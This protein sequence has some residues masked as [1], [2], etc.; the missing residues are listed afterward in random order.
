MDYGPMEKQ[1]II[2]KSTE[3]IGLY[4]MV[5][6]TMMNTCSLEYKIQDIQDKVIEIHKL[7]VGD[8][9]A[10]ISTGAPGLE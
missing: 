3:R 9:S 10:E 8:G 1:N 4:L 7:Y 2:H 5:F 6:I